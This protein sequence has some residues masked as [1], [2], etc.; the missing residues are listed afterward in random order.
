MCW[1]QAQEDGSVVAG[2]ISVRR[3]YFGR[4]KS[5]ASTCSQSNPRIFSPSVSQVYCVLSPDLSW[6]YSATFLISLGPFD[7]ILTI[8]RVFFLRILT[9]SIS[10]ASGIAGPAP[11]EQWPPHHTRNK[12]EHI[13]EKES[14][15]ISVTGDVRCTHKSLPYTLNSHLKS[16]FDI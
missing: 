9:T 2:G 10:M 1:T 7:L 16:M 6:L 4:W 5:S 3:K 11:P 12:Q 15:Q 14:L 13:R 8:S